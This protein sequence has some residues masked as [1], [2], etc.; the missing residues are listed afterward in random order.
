MF[1][2][3]K[4]LMLDIVVI[5]LAEF[6]QEHRW[7]LID[8]RHLA[9]RKDLHRGELHL[10]RIIAEPL[11]LMARWQRQHRLAL[12]CRPPRYPHQIRRR[13]H[14]L[15]GRLERS[16]QHIGRHAVLA[17]DRQRIAIGIEPLA[18]SAGAG[19]HRIMAAHMIG[20][21]QKG[22]VDHIAA[23]VGLHPPGWLAVVIIEPPL[24]LAHCGAVILHREQ[25]DHTP[26]RVALNV[27]I[28]APGTKDLG[29]EGLAPAEGRGAVI[30]RRAQHIHHT[31]F[32]LLV[33]ALIRGRLKDLDGQTGHGRRQEVD[34]RPDARKRQGLAHAHPFAHLA[35]EHLRNRRLTAVHH[36][37]ALFWRACIMRRRAPAPPH[38]SHSI[39][40]RE[41]SSSPQG[42]CSLPARSRH[43]AIP[44]DIASETMPSM[45]PWAFSLSNIRCPVRFSA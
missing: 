2:Q 26:L 44:A 42:D 25:V 7:Q 36:L 27:G 3:V 22:D 34:R 39:S 9:Y 23:R 15:F 31:A 37:G 18:D 8:P 17:K 29:K 24:I 14:H 20:F 6:L 13:A 30:H 11:Q 21:E 5:A 16:R 41:Y 45:R 10:F 4:I 35:G 19:H 40:S 32:E 1:D 33:A 38:Q 12:I 28:G 43:S